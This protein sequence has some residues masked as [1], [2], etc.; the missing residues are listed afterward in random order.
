MAK[1]NKAL[2]EAI[3]TTVD[4]DLQ[5][6][7]TSETISPVTIPEIKTDTLPESLINET[8]EDMK[9]LQ[10]QTENEI[11]EID[12]AKLS[13]ES[14][15]AATHFDIIRKGKAIPAHALTVT[16]Q[17]LADCERDIRNR[18]SEL[19]PMKQGTLE[20]VSYIAFDWVYDG[21]TNRKYSLSVI[22]LIDMRYVVGSDISAYDTAKF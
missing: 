2:T 1:K 6:L 13:I 5:A 11:K 10:T 22:D 3:K 17:S 15:A 12:A 7:Q 19:S 21:I 16:A 14:F 8:I 20:G 4:Q 18:H 9:A